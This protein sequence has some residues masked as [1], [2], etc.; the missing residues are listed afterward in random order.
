MR[1]TLSRSLDPVLFFFFNS[2]QENSGK[3]TAIAFLRT[4]LYQLLTIQ[5]NS[6]LREACFSILYPVVEQ[7]GHNE[8]N[9]IEELWKAAA[10]IFVQVPRLC[11]VVDALD[12]CDL[13]ERVELLEKLT[14]ITRSTNTFKVV[15]TSRPEIDISKF[16]ENVSPDGFLRLSFSKTHVSSDLKIYIQSRLRESDII[17]GKVL[18]GEVEKKLLGRADVSS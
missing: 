6:K 17:V 10:D 18:Q 14:S 12:E 15:I 1:E 7:S 4:I 11:L 8:A 3:R 13:K 9:S 16:F 5:L 2:K